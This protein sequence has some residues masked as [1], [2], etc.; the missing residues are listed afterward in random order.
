MTPEERSEM[1]YL[2]EKIATE[3]YAE[4][5]DSLVDELLALVEQKHK[6]IRSVHQIKPNFPISSNN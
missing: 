3:Q 4:K 2:C 1:A 5:F 6:R